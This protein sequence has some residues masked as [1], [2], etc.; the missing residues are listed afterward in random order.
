MKIKKK[1]NSTL[2]TSRSSSKIRFFTA[3]LNLSI[4]NESSSFLSKIKYL[5]FIKMSHNF[6]LTLETLSEYRLKQF[7]KKSFC[8]KKDVEK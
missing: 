1:A 5:S 6:L 4:K 7:K 3:L 8:F 2:K